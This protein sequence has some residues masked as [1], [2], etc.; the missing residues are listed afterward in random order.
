LSGQG[1]ERVVRRA[2]HLWVGVRCEAPEFGLKRRCAD[3]AGYEQSHRQMLAPGDRLGDQGLG[4]LAALNE[5]H[6]RSAPQVSVPRVQGVD[7]RAPRWAE[8]GR[9][10]ERLQREQPRDL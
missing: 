8:P 7:E 9:T 1:A 4:T 3:V 10:P 6:T 2:C 5:E